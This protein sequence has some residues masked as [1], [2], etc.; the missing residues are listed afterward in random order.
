MTAIKTSHVL[1]NDFELVKMIQN[2]MNTHKVTN[3]CIKNDYFM[4][5]NEIIDIINI[6]NS[7]S[8]EQIT[9]TFITDCFEN[10]SYL[11]LGV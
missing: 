3:L 11:E 1:N 7:N 10:I 4:S 2:T 5:A 6:H 8:A 9:A